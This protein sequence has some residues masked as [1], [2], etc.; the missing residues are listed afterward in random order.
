M[1]NKTRS[2]KPKESPRHRSLNKFSNSISLN[3]SDRHPWHI[4]HFQNTYAEEHSFLTKWL[5]ERKIPNYWCDRRTF[6]FPHMP[7]MKQQS[8]WIVLSKYLQSGFS[9]QEDV[10]SREAAH[11][12]SEH[13]GPECESH[14]KV[15]SKTV[16]W[17]VGLFWKEKRHNNSAKTRNEQLTPILLRNLL[18]IAMIQYGI[19]TAGFFVIVFMSKIVTEYSSVTPES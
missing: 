18:N 15:C 7:E 8:L 13:D 16:D 3:N 19:R 6:I 4:F 2:H 11:W 14:S 10:T 1:R 17:K 9:M 12:R 5:M